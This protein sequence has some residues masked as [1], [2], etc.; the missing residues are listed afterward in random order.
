M[1]NEND[2]YDVQVV[3][4]PGFL[5]DHYDTAKKTVDLSPDVYEGRNVSAAAVA[6][7]ESG[8][9]VQQA[10][11]NSMLMMRRRLVPI[12]QIST[13]LSQW[14]IITGLGT[15]A[16]PVETKRCYQLVLYFLP[17]QPCSH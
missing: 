5:S 15:L 3:S 1:L 6:A 12:T 10:T 11:A 16:L 17:S 14:F 2:I 8:H 7:H 9:A 13:S 4:V